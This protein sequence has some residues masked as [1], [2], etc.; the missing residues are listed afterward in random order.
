MTVKEVTDDQRIARIQPLF[1]KWITLLSLADWDITWQ[2]VDKLAGPDGDNAIAR[3]TPIWPYQRAHIRLVRKA[4]DA[5]GLPG[6]IETVIVH[7][8]CHL[9]MAP[10]WEA[11][12]DVLGGGTIANRLHGHMETLMDIF[13]L[14]LQYSYD[15]KPRGALYSPVLEGTPQ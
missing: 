10:L 2:F 14:G 3:V 15:K 5:A 9:V 12:D 11:I 1:T 13:A 7:E 6:E 4:V 8:L